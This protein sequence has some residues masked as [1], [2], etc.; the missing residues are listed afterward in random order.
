MRVR[1]ARPAERDAIAAVH[2]R[3]IREIAS[4]AYSQEVIEAWASL[5]GDESDD[6]EDGEASDVDGERS[7]VDGET[8]DL[9][10]ETD[11]NGIQ[12]EDGKL[13]VAVVGED[14]DERQTTIAG[15]GDV[16]FHPP[17]YL[18][19]PADGGVRAVYVDP[20][21]TGEGAGSALLERLEAAARDRGLA[22]LGLQSS[23]NARSFYEA[24]GYDPVAEVTFEFGEEV[25]GP[26]VE[27]RKAL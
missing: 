17:D 11:P 14:T 8:S 4:E 3:S 15:F 1:E 13:F 19:E 26:A 22:S 25:E 18:R 10:G 12:P 21:H 16:R 2:E 23:V 5:S 9:D 27:M 6:R 7:D 20:D 24:H